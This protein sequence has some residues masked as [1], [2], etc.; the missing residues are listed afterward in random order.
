MKRFLL[1]I[2]PIGAFVL[3]VA[4]FFWQ[5]FLGK[6]P[7][8]AD[9]LVGLYH[10]W[11][12]YYASDYPRGV[13]FKNFLITDPVR[14]QIPWRKLAVES[15]KHGEIPWWN[16]YTF[17]GSPLAGNIQAGVFYPLN[18]LFIFFPFS[19][20]WTI[21][22]VLQPLL[23]GILLYIFL[24]RMAIHPWAAFLGAVSWSFSGFSVSWLTW[25]TI[26]QT[27]IWL[28]LILMGIDDLVA[29]KKLWFISIFVG[30]TMTFLAGH[31]QVALYVYLLSLAYF[32][33]RGTEAI[34]RLKAMP[35]K[36]VMLMGILLTVTAAQW[37]PFIESVTR[38]ARTQGT[39][40]HEAGF[41]LPWKHLSGFFAPDF[42]GNP[43]TLNYWGTWN[44]AEFA[45]YIGTIPLLFALIA[46]IPF[47]KEGKFWVWTALISL[48]FSLPTIVA[49]LPYQTNIPVISS[50]QPTRLMILIDFAL[51]VLS[52]I[53]FSGFLKKSLRVKFPL[54]AMA[55]VYVILWIVVFVLMK[56]KSPEAISHALVARRNLILPTALFSIGAL[57]I[58]VSSRLRQLRKVVVFL[59]IAISVGDLLRF[60]WK[61]TPFTPSDYLFP[62]TSVIRF[63][64]NQ[65]GPFRVMSL[66]DRI[67]PP[68]ASSYF[69]IETTEGY[70]PLY[71]SAYETFFAAMTRAD[72]SIAKP[73]GFNRIL[74]SKNIDSPLLPFL[75]VKYVLTLE[76]VSRPYLVKV[77]QEGETRVY[78]YKKS[79]DRVGFAERVISVQDPQ[80]A[81]RALAQSE[82][83]TLAIVDKTVSLLP[84]PLR[85][86]EG[87]RITSY[88]PNS[89]EI[90]TMASN[91]RLLVIY[92]SYHP[93]WIATIDNKE[94][95]VVKTDG[96][97]MGVVVPA[98]THTVRLYYHPF[99]GI[100]LGS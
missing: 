79:L 56:Q 77:Y 3:V 28:P 18:V 58:Y 48:L 17:S 29:G 20:A 32:L 37:V 65:T 69:G 41:F 71:S 19:V 42:F 40:W 46:S 50:L 55:G 12:D 1:S 84:V 66:D 82:A 47:W 60:A 70:D 11:R 7:I 73:Y 35:W 16:P 89:I 14:Q 99:R 36:F 98:G 39:G 75:N 38:S 30:I 44:W 80:E 90:K 64:K 88:T 100:L 92:N 53:G 21:L 59:L 63:L 74:T 83:G 57:G 85:L 51:A 8:P 68:N 2:L 4:V 45:G 10:P 33:A 67:L 31:I 93:S 91:P 24:T 72:M 87:T 34:R 95:P 76:E 54:L 52:S 43:A 49:K 5:L 9:S 27:A 25:G 94:A 96:I 86:G 97:F 6:L 15:W 78:E 22:I 26:V 81:L 62:E 23:G 13:P 61:F